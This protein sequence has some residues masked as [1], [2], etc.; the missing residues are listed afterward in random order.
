MGSRAN[1]GPKYLKAPASLPF[2]GEAGLG[3]PLPEIP[4]GIPAPFGLKYLIVP[5]PRPFGE[6]ASAGAPPPD[7][8]YKGARIAFGR[9]PVCV[10]SSGDRCRSPRPEIPWDPRAG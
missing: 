2:G 5:V 1:F 9:S 8:P 3:A 10:R 4:S 6:V 7:T